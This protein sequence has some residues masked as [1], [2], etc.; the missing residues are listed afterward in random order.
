MDERCRTR[1]PILLV[2]GL[3]FHDHARLNYWGRIPE[4]LREHGAEV[5]YGGQ[6]SH[7]PVSSNGRFLYERLQEI[8][9]HTGA[10]KVNIIAHSKGG[11][12]SRWMITHLDRGAHVASLTTMAT[13]HHGS[14]TADLLLRLPD[15]LVR[16]AAFV[17]DLWYRLLGDRE[18][19]SYEVFH[20]LT[21]ERSEALN[22]ETPDVDGVFY[23]SFAFV[24]KHL[25]SDLLLWFPCL[26][27]RLVEGRSDGLVTPD[28]AAWGSFRGVYTGS[29]SRGISHCD[30][31]DLRRRRFTGKKSRK[32]T[33]V[34]DIAEFYCGLVE[35]L[36]ENGF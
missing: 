9:V 29:G 18:P 2:H 32:T 19:D 35:E 24:M 12:D 33:E 8:L 36:R 22:K 16:A 11:L 17:C 23:Q 13:P 25:Y 15:R 5:F 28:S 27:V 21:T 10:E 34:S 7:A 26:V 3:G 31:V 1:Y 20:G 14:R 6:D 30:E 4:K